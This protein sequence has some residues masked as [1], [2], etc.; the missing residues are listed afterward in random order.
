[1]AL[2]VWNIAKGAG[3]YYAQRERWEQAEVR[4]VDFALVFISYSKGEIGSVPISPFEYDMKNG[5]KFT[6][7][8][9]PVLISPFEQNSL[10]TDKNVFAMFI[11]GRHL[12]RHLPV[13]LKTMY[14][15]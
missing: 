2:L 4:C 5:A 12:W 15:T 6:L 9:W 1:M 3:P 8:I 11:F 10:P 13:L 7:L 14:T